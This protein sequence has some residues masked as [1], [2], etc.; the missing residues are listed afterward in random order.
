MYSVYS[1][2][3]FMFLCGWVP[4]ETWH[5][6]SET[7]FRETSPPSESPTELDGSRS[8]CKLFLC[9]LVFFGLL[10]LSN[11]HLRLEEDIHL[12]GIFFVISFN[13]WIQP[14]HYSHFQI[15]ASLL[16]QHLVS[17]HTEC[18]QPP[19]SLHTLLT[20]LQIPKG[21]KFTNNMF[22]TT[23]PEHIAVVPGKG[24]VGLGV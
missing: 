3:R 2:N 11:T 22:L 23:S 9:S 10:L 18:N 19:Y 20:C 6:F 5:T 4:V 17:S 12:Y 21:Y 15:E 1:G 7:V 13:K 16:P 8:M 14:G 24:S